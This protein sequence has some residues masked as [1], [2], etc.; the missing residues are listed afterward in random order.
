[1]YGCHVVP[2]N[3]ARRRPRRRLL[4][5]RGLLDRVRSRD[6][7]ARHLGARRG[8]RPARRRART[9]SSSTFPPVGSRPGPPSPD[10]RVRSVR[11]RNVPVVRL[12]ARARGGGDGW[13]TSRTA[14]RSTRSL[15]ERVEPRRA[16]APDRARPRRSRRR[17]RPSTRSCTRSSRSSTASTAWSSGRT[18]ATSRSRSGTSRCSPTARSTDH[19]AG[20]ARRRAS[21]CSTRRA[22]SRAASRSGTCRS[23]ARSSPGASWAQTEVAGRPAVVT[24]VEGTAYRTGAATFELDPDDPLGEGFSASRV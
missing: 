5:Q 6:D 15:E 16:A 20:A 21:R 8:H 12:G 24:E 1:M 11:F 17:S 2:P 10:G 7:R 23:S 14:A 13:S 9:A 4:P 18:R 19:R 22:G 3:D